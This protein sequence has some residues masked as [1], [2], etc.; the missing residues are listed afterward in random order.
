[1]QGRVKRTKTGTAEA[2]INVKTH[3][4]SPPLSQRSLS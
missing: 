4:D 2:I 1:M 3:R